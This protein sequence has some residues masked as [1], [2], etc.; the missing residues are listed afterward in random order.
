[1]LGQRYGYPCAYPQYVWPEAVHKY[2]MI[3]GIVVVS[4]VVVTAHVAGV[5]RRAVRGSPLGH[6]GPG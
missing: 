6:K 4:V 3:V 5:V 1:M 2:N